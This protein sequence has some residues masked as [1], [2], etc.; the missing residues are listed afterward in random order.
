MK[1]RFFNQR[2]IVTLL[3]FFASTTQAEQ[4]IYLLGR[5][6]LENSTYGE[7][8]FFYDK[9]VASLKDCEDDIA[10]SNTGQWQY[11]GHAV[12]KRKGTATTVS[13]TCMTTDLS[14]SEWQSTNRYSHVYLIDR[15]K[16]SVKIIPQNN[17]ADCL[18]VLR[19]TQKEESNTYFCAKSNQ[20]IDP[21]E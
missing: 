8:V 20:Q 14:I 12:R 21:P 11:Y 16:Q 4:R 7:A 1:N 3:I 17:Y 18:T 2:L 9:D 13:Y 6:A 5:A 19:K 15:R 10:R